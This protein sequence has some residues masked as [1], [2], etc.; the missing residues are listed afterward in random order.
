[1]C[2]QSTAEDAR[3]TTDVHVKHSRA[4]AR[5][6]LACVA[7][8]SED[9]NARSQTTHRLVELLRAASA[10]RFPVA[11]GAV[12]I[13]SSPPGPA[14]AVVAFTGRHIVAA[15]IESRWVHDV[16]PPDDLGAPMKAPFITQLARRINSSPGM[17]D[18]VLVARH[19][20]SKGTDSHV[21]LL[22]GEPDHP[23][24]ARARRYRRQLRCY[25]DD[26]GGLLVIGRGLADRWE[27]SLE[28]DP[29]SRG[30]GRGA[31]LARAAIASMD[32][33]ESIFAQVSPGNTASLRCFLAA[34]YEP[35]GAE[36][37]FLRN[38]AASDARW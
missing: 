22:K 34:G 30:Q 19:D 32:A 21:R 33:N 18:L 6:K 9:E 1:M 26:R 14:D 3:S 20:G 16:L 5:E 10:G 29:S 37:L 17:V 38:E 11:N 12:E 2:A 28:V 15:D 31:A 36:V 8:P 23:R 24:V 25:T 13:T 35:I 4:T 27:V 7:A